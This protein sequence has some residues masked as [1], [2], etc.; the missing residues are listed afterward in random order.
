MKKL[1]IALL[2]LL[3]FVVCAQ[4]ADSIKYYKALAVPDASLKVLNAEFGSM[5]AY[6]QEDPNYIAEIRAMAAK[7]N[8]Q[9]N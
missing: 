1:F 9:K 7:I 8:K 3:P 5:P 4:N 2:I 6:Q